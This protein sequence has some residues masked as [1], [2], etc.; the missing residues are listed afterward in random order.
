[1]TFT[2]FVQS[3]DDDGDVMASFEKFCV[4]AAS[5]THRRAWMNMTETPMTADDAESKE[6]EKALFDD[7]GDDDGGGDSDWEMAMEHDRS[8]EDLKDDHAVTAMA[9]S[10]SDQ[11]LIS[12]HR[13]GDIC[14]WS[15]ESKESNDDQFGGSNQLGKRRVKRSNFGFIARGSMRRHSEKVTSLSLSGTCLVSSSVDGNVLIWHLVC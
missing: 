4:S 15:K 13:D 8:G 2:Q 11:W 12:G 1:M 10:V 7:D 14:F 9:W 3:V 5:R 6:E